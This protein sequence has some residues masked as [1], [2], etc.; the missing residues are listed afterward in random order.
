[1]HMQ[2]RFFE[3]ELHPEGDTH[4]TWDAMVS[5][6]PADRQA[7]AAELQMLWSVLPRW[8]GS[9]PAPLDEGGDW[10]VWL[11]VQWDGGSPTTLSLPPPD[12]KWIAFDEPSQ[13]NWLTLTVTLSVVNELAPLL[14]ERWAAA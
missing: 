11:Q 2:L 9:S 6:R 3:F 12:G 14:A 13:A 7:L 4:T 1:M 8:L 10:D 5:V